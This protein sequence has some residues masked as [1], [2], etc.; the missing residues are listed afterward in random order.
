MFNSFFHS[1]NCDSSPFRSASDAPQPYTTAFQVERC[2]NSNNR[3][4]EY[5][6]MKAILGT[7][8]SFCD[9]DVLR[10]IFQKISTAADQSR[11]PSLSIIAPY[12][13]AQ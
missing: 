7:R 4:D 1:L 13:R 12:I 6:R 10:L 9:V 2:G 5:H 11:W 8:Q 3:D